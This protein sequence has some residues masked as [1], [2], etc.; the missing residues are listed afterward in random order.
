MAQWFSATFSPGRDPGV[1]DGVL[2]PC[3]AS[4]SAY[5]SDSLSL[6]LC[7]MN[8]QD[9]K[10]KKK[11]GADMCLGNSECECLPTYLSQKYL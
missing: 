2:V 3:P 7:F 9:L 6:S 4:P 5:V 11:I 8:K 1:R 10:K